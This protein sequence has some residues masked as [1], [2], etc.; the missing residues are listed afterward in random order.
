M[1]L[2]TSRSWHLLS[3]S[4]HFE[5]ALRLKTVQAGLKAFERV[6]SF[7][8]PTTR[9]IQIFGSYATKAVVKIDR[10]ELRRLLSGESIPA[11]H[12]W[13]QGYVILAVDGY[14]VIGLGLLV[15]GQV[16][17]QLRSRELSRLGW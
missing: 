3:K 16:R 5:Q 12:E 13:G 14:G 17:S 11:D 15:G 8:K 2:K 10:L 4:A 7:I 9:F 1:L 6:G